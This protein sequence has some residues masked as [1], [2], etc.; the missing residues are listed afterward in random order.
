MTQ[1]RDSDGII[2][3]HSTGCTTE[4]AANVKLSKF[5]KEAE[6]IAAGIRKKDSG[7]TVD[8]H[9]LRHS[10]GTLLSTSGEA[11]RTAQRA[12]RHSRIGLKMNT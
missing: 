4:A 1:Y 10:F 8:V 3:E 9:A 11:L 12:E 6:R 2:R 7:R 5:I